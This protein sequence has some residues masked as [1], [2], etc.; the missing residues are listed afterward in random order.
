M[1][2]TVLAGAREGRNRPA[3]VD[4]QIQVELQAGGSGLMFGGAVTQKVT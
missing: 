3:K 1:L 4:R 2:E